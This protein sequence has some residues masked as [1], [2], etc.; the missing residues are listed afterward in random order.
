MGL[1]RRIGL[2]V[3]CAV[4]AGASAVYGLWV[5][6]LAGQS[7][8]HLLACL[9]SDPGFVAWHCE[10]ILRH[11]RMRKEA[12]ADLNASAGVRFPLYLRDAA[13]GRELARSMVQQGVDVNAPDVRHKRLTALHGAVLSGSMSEARSL[14]ELGARTDVVDSEGRSPLDLA[15][16]LA[17]KRPDDPH[18]R[19]LIGLLERAAM[20]TAN[21][22]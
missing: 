4:L 2:A 14:L 19:D 1:R 7:P 15:R 22:R 16:Q 3:G 17:Q 5:V 6:G 9:D 8:G 21:P 11:V 10:R 20:D 12:V 13:L 18:L